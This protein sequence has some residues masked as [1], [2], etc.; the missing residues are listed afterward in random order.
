[1][2]VCDPKDPNA[3][4]YCYNRLDRVGV[5]YVCPNAAQEGVFEMCDGENMDFV[6]VYTSAS[7]TI[8]YSQPPESDGPITTM[9]YTARIPASSNCVTFQSTDLFAALPTAS[10]NSTS[11][12]ASASATAGASKNAAGASASRTGASSSASATGASNQ[13]NG[14]ASVRASAFA[15]LAGVV[16]AMAFFA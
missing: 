13:T 5:S 9:P 14:V 11:S 4:S 15:T 7:Q 8:T 6:G 16:F 10:A 12:S 2:K 1:M 3:A